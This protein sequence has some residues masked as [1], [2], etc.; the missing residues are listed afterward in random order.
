MADPFTFHAGTTPV[1]VSLPHGSTYIPSEISE[2][3][4]DAASRTPDTDWHMEQLYDFA[5]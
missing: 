1:L 5:A 3:M 2:R 4:T